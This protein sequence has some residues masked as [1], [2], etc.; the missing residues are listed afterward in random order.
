VSEWYEVL[1]LGNQMRTAKPMAMARQLEQ[2]QDPC[3]K[4]VDGLL[5]AR[6]NGENRVPHR[7]SYYV[8]S[9]DR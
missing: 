1:S 6:W 2:L 4:Q 7:I 8:P 3:F 9:S 5:E